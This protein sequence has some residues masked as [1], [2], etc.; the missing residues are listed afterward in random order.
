MSLYIEYCQKADEFVKIQDFENA[1]N[2][3]TKA[4]NIN[5]SEILAIRIADMFSRISLFENIEQQ[6]FWIQKALEINP[7][8][9]LA[10]RNLAWLYIREENLELAYP[11][12]KKL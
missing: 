3:Y 5:M 12:F 2:F 11:L 7:E 8:S 6:H 10:F 4:F 1:I 9:S